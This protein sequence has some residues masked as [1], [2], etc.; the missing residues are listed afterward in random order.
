MLEIIRNGGLGTGGTNFDAKLRRN[1]TDLEDLFI[2]HISGMDAMARA[3]LNA[4]AILENSELPQMKKE[5]YA[6]FDSGIGKD[7]EE[8]R[9]TMEQIYEYGKKVEEPRQTSGKQ[10]KYET[11][12]ALYS[13]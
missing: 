3:L 13:I 2:A 9:L 12:V 8:G 1:S 10:E 5:R 6:S 7:F 4:A 11:I